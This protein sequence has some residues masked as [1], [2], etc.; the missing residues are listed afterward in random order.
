MKYR[1]IVLI[2]STSIFLVV[3]GCNQDTKEHIMEDV[4]AQQA[5]LADTTLSL[6]P[7]NKVQNK[8]R[9]AKDEALI[10]YVDKAGFYLHESYLHLDQLT[11]LF[12]T[13]NPRTE[14]L[15]YSKGIVQKLQRESEPLLK[16]EPPGPLEGFHTIHVTMMIEIDA[17]ERVLQDMKE[18]NNAQLLNARSHYEKAVF[19]HKQAEREYLSVLEEHGLK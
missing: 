5:R 1:Q 19:A 8:A 16:T 3:Y 11:A 7:N 15:A 13:N 4:K 14:Q 17:L 6:P 10:S 12:Q 2:V 9:V 18:P